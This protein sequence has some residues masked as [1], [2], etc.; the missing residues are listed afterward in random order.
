MCT[1]AELQSFKRMNVQNKEKGLRIIGKNR[2]MEHSEEKIKDIENGWRTRQTQKE[3][4]MQREQVKGHFTG[5]KKRK[6]S[7]PRKLF[8]IWKGG[9]P[10]RKAGWYMP[11]G[12]VYMYTAAVLS[13]PF[14]LTF[15]NSYLFLMTVL[16][17]SISEFCGITLWIIGYRSKTVYQSTAL[18]HSRTNMCH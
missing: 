17:L 12:T 6:A 9:H 14:F 5:R 11:W 16:H 18:N 13:A 2:E 10:A 4:C 1:S 7:K 15:Y 3:R 8:L